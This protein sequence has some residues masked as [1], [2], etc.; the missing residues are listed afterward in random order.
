M[1]S[2]ILLVCVVIILIQTTLRDI[3]NNGKLEFTLKD[4]KMVGR[5]IVLGTFHVDLR[6]IYSF[7][8]D[9]NTFKG[10]MQ[11]NAKAIQNSAHI[12]G[13]ISFR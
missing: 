7:R 13:A 5:D 10:V 3:V 9:Q 4:D 6:A 11:N 2:V 12:Q 8:D 1:F